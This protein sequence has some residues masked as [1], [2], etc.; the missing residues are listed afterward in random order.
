MNE[1]TPLDWTWFTSGKGTVGVIKVMTDHGEIKYRI[2]AV[3]GF[4][5]KMD[6]LQLIAWGADFPAH[7]GE[8]LFPRSEK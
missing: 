3:D 4:M 2:G 5:E 8:A 6:V 1:S 7:A